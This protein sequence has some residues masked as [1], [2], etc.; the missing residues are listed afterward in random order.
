MSHFPGHPRDDPL[1]NL[2]SRGALHVGMT[3]MKLCALLFLAMASFATVAEA[4][5]GETV[6]QCMDR[7]GPVIERRP[8]VLGASDPEALVFSKSGVTVIVEYRESKAWQISYRKSKMLANEV[9]SLVTANSG[10][11]MWS[12]AL[13]LAIGEWRISSD[14]ARLAV[15]GE[16]SGAKPGTG[17]TELR[18]MTREW[19]AENRSAYIRKAESPLSAPERVKINPLPGF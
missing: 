8:A 13:K 6:E 5:L 1:R 15:L 4:R 9:E 7:Y 10:E 16:I 19:L 17:I 12:S 18:V 2:D 3:H 14:R 11:G